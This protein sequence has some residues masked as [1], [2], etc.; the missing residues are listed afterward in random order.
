MKL[1]LAVIGSLWLGCLLLA[2]CTTQGVEERAYLTPVPEETLRAYHDGTPI[3]NE[4]QAVIAARA[5]L[6]TSRMENIGTPA[7]IS[8]EQITLAEAQERVEKPGVDTHIDLPPDT[9][10]WFVLFK[11]TWRLNPPAPGETVAPPPEFEGCQYVWIPAGN[12]GYSATGNIECPD[13]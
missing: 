3:A 8:A 6:S 7:V 1:R 4:M 13:E 12:D 5:F 10:V 9:P 11:G 2:G